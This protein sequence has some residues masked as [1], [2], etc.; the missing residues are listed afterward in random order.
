[1]D[2]AIV[3]LLATYLLAQASNAPSAG[4]FHGSPEAGDSGDRAL[5]A[6]KNRSSQVDMRPSPAS[7]YTGHPQPRKR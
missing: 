2:R 1:M 7:N 4:K 3:L 6:Q 5:N